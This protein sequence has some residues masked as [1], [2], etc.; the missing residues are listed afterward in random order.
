M[1]HW[2]G[3]WR[4]EKDRWELND[5]WEPESGNQAMFKEKPRS[6]QNSANGKDLEKSDTSKWRDLSIFG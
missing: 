2:N 5:T 6:K 1:R 3:I 4:A